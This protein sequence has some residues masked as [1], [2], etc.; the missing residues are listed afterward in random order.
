VGLVT[1]LINEL[2]AQSA[3]EAV[4]VLDDYHVIGSQPV[5]TSLE[6]L[7]E[8]RPPGLR[9]VLAELRAAQLQFAGEAAVLPRQ[10]VV[11][12]DASLPDADVAALT[13]PTEG[14]AAGLQ[15]AGLSLRGQPDVALDV[16]A[17]RVEAV[18][19]LVEAAEQ[20]H[21]AAAEEPLDPPAGRA[22]SLLLNILA[23][24]AVHRSP[25]AMPRGDAEATAT[26]ASRALAELG[27]DEREL[28]R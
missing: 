23:L 22:E 10:L 21:M 17:G 1:A 16:D 14:W 12:A 20:A 3:D 4:L 18:E 8:H 6:F 19:R 11:G 28:M 13:A 26:F 9:L 5:H 15:L 27:G 2:A 24:I 25:L 7:L